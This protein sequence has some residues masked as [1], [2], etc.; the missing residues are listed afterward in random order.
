[1]YP[2]IQIDRDFLPKRTPLHEGSIPELVK[3]YIIDD[4]IPPINMNYRTMV[5]EA[6]HMLKRLL[7]EKAKI[8]NYYEQRKIEAI[9]HF[10]L[11]KN[12]SHYNF[13]WEIQLLY[14]GKEYRISNK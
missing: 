2:I 3:E 1:M 6:N 13:E 4:F 5:I 11:I 8:S 12:R 9:K 14:D 7:L 10:I